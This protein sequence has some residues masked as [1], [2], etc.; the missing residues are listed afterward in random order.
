MTAFCHPGLT[1][2]RYRTLVDRF[3]TQKIA[4]KALDILFSRLLPM[5]IFSFGE[6]PW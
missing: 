1:S 6:G 3:R 4:K 5:S 2:V